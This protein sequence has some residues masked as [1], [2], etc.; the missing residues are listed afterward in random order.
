MHKIY[1][2]RK[3]FLIHH[4]NILVDIYKFYITLNKSICIKIFYLVSTKRRFL[5]TRIYLRIVHQ[6]II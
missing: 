5:N 3:Q 1:Y 4:I 2:S 6:L